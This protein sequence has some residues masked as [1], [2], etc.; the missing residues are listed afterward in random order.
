MTLQTDYMNSLRTHYGMLPVDETYLNL[1]P[2]LF[3]ISNSEYG[4]DD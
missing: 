3:Q 1:V 4:Y 2:Y